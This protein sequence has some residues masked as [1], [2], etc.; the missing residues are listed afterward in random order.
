LTA[1][2]IITAARHS[3]LKAIYILGEDLLNTTPE[4]A[5]V[6]QALSGCEFVILQEIAPSETARYA[7]VHLPGVSFAEK[8]GTYTN[9]ERR[10]QLIHQAIQPIGDARPDWQII[11][12][13]AN[14]ILA[15]HNKNVGPAPFSAWDYL[16][17]NQ[18]VAE[19]AALS[20]IYANFTPNR[21]ANEEI[22]RWNTPAITPRFIP[23]EQI[24]LEPETLPLL[25]LA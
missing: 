18:I 5:E 14:R 3:Q 10:I 13:I 8:S 22:L 24:K 19:I 1:S 25:Q 12:S 17:P 16:D 7:D 23:A 15:A 11:A 2:E 20:P 9:A 6:R 4:A 21:L